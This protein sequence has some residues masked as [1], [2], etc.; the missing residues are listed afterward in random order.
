MPV[1]TLSPVTLPQDACLLA[2]MTML[3]MYNLVP[4]LYE[5][6][7]KWGDSCSFLE[8]TPNTV[9]ATLHVVLLIGIRGFGKDA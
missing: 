6:W 9:S 3:H 1:R 7:K 2:S 8:E 4:R 5:A